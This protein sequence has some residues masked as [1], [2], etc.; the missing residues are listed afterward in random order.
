MTVVQ[1]QSSIGR[2]KI[3]QLP[4]ELLTCGWAAFTK[5]YPIA[6]TR[7][8]FAP[9]AQG[10]HP[11]LQAS[12]LISVKDGRAP[13][14]HSVDVPHRLGKLVGLTSLL[15]LAPATAWADPPENTAAETPEGP[16]TPTRTDPFAG[17]VPTWGGFGYASPGLVVGS[18][19]SNAELQSGLGEGAEASPW[20]TSVGGGGGMLFA[21]RWVVRGHGYALFG[22]SSS[23]QVGQTQITGGG[24]G[25]DL[26]LIVHNRRGT[27]LYPYVGV[28]GAG[29]NVS[30][31]NRSDQPIE[32]AGRTIDPNAT[33]DFDAGFLVLDVGFAF[34]QLL[35]RPAQEGKLKGGGGFIH[36]VQI[37]LQA[38]LPA[39]SGEGRSLG[40]DQQLLGYVRILIGGGGFFFR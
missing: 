9:R 7:R 31:I 4:L 16:L 29:Q 11:H 15:T 10:V 39:V 3:A 13:W 36:G 33:E 14:G 24:G 40:A 12:A 19:G 5:P 37:G 34:Q 26:G 22:P 1:S 18:F 28:G 35:F 21:R 38:S 25:L 6:Q 32:V 2:R 23:T 30:V 17:A 20:A 8:R 27:L